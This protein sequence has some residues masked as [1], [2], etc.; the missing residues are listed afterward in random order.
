MVRNNIF[1]G[2]PPASGPT[3][4]GAAPKPTEKRWFNERKPRADE[5]FSSAEVKV[6]HGQFGWAIFRFFLPFFLEFEIVPSVRA[7][8]RARRLQEKG[9]IFALKLKELR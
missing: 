7:F 4:F 5:I 8:Y 6:R 1:F 3:S 9:R 2:R